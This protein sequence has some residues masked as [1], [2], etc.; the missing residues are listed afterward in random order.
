MNDIQLKSAVAFGLLALTLA[1]CNEQGR[2]VEKARPETT[3]NDAIP[4]Q[5]VIAPNSP[6]LAQIKTESLESFLVPVGT[7]AAGRKSRG[8]CEPAVACRVAIG[9]PRD[10]GARPDW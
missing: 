1:G 8:Q 10:H 3:T 5:A 9:R 4:G 6:Q 7:V 2:V